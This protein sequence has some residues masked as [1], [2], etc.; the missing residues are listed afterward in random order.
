MRMSRSGRLAAWHLPGG[1]VGPPSRWAAKSNVEVGQTIHLVNRRR[2]EREGS[3]GQSHKA[4]ERER[5]TKSQS[6]G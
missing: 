3:E 6:E 5:G 4:K 1:P 2:A